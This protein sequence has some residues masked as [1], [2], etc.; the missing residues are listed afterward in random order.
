MAV[1]FHRIT[2]SRCRVNVFILPLLV[3]LMPAALMTLLFASFRQCAQYSGHVCLSA[4]HFGV[5]LV[6][7]FGSPTFGITAFQRRS[8]AVGG[9]LRTAGAA[10]R[11]AR[12][13]LS[14]GSGWHHRLAWIALFLA[15]AGCCYAAAG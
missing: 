5:G 2:V 13:A 3:V 7:L 10:H 11:A 8:L 9:F 6:R 12:L 15:R 14:S 1:Y 4:L